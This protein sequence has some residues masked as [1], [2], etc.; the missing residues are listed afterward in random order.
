MFEAAGDRQP[1][2]AA[3]GAV[4]EYERRTDSKQ[5]ASIGYREDL[6]FIGDKA[7]P[8]AVFIGGV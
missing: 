6:E 5:E 1:V 2:E 7:F 4:E 8:L 3:D